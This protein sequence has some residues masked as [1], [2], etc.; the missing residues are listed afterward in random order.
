M[1][2]AALKMLTHTKFYP[3]W[4]LAASIEKLL[5]EAAPHDPSRKIVVA[6]LGDQAGS[7][8]ILKYLA[9]HSDLSDRLKFAD[10]LDEAL[11]CGYQVGSQRDAGHHV[12]AQ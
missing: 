8:A 6:P 11:D 5:R 3:L 12:T 2:R 10:S 4:E 9:A 1:I 7:T